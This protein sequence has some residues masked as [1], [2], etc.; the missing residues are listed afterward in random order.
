MGSDL[1]CGFAIFQPSELCPHKPGI[2][3]LITLGAGHGDPLPALDSGWRRN[4]GNGSPVIE[5]RGL[6]PLWIMILCRMHQNVQ[7]HTLKT[8][9]WA[10]HHDLWNQT[11]W[12]PRTCILKKIPRGF[13]SKVKFQT[14]CLRECPTGLERVAPGWGAQHG[15]LLGLAVPLL[16]K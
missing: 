3:R 12:G 8:G 16:A 4:G 11:L 15:L 6:H 2:N 5:V 1:E 10:P 7:Q 13:L 9:S 14:C